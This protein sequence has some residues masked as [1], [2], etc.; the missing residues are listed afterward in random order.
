[1]KALDLLWLGNEEKGAGG[2]LHPPEGHIPGDPSSPQTPMFAINPGKH[3]WAMSAHHRGAGASP[4]G[5]QW[6]SEPYM[7]LY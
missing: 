4:A 3:T 2:P 1:M 6:G 7:R 5:V